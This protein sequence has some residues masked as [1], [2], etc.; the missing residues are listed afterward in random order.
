MK[1]AKEES[2]RLLNFQKQQKNLNIN[3][4]IIYPHCGRRFRKKDSKRN[5]V[6]ACAF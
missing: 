2:H 6:K 1:N 5:L 4:V 3:E